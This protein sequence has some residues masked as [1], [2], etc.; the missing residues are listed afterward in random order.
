LVVVNA[1]DLGNEPMRFVAF[2]P[3]ISSMSW[4]LV[5]VI[6]VL[7]FAFVRGSRSIRRYLTIR[8]L[9]ILPIM[10]LMGTTVFIIMRVVPGDP[11]SA[12]V[13]QYGTPELRERVRAELGLDD[14][15]A[16]Q[17]GRFL[18]GVLTLDF[19]QSVTGGRRNVAQEISERL[20]ATAELVIPG[21]VLSVTFGVV[22]GVAAA[23][24]RGK[25]LDHS[26]RL[27]SVLSQAI[28][29]FFLGLILQLVFGLGLG[30][31][32]IAG[33]V[34]EALVTG[35]GSGDSGGFLL[36]RSLL[37]GD[38]AIAASAAHHLILPVVTI[39]WIVVGT[40]V[41]IARI[42]MIE[43]LHSDYILA[44]TARGIRTSVL[45]YRYAFRNALLP[46]VTFLGLQM[47]LLMGG[48]VVI[49]TVFSWPGLGKYVLD[50]ILARDF[51]AIEGAIVIITLFV[52]LMALLVDAL[53][54]VIDPRVEL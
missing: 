7:I 23:V 33:R 27:Y 1:A 11:V 8:I 47:A 21:A 36:V 43:A 18:K 54:T 13:Q 42:N 2:T 25:V 26:V 4:V 20:P 14:P 32:P 9:S 5:P 19:G 45:K 52:V 39:T 50:R 28:P 38:W 37:Q 49:E 48:T 44:G 40:N 10:L 29:G 12:N 30:L 31:T 22:F 34:D 16:V 3:L 17:Y 41:R 53:Y 6:G 51:P 15:I 24:K 46:I 35:V